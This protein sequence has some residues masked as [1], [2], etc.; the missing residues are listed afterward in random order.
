MEY[1]PARQPGHSASC[2]L[3]LLHRPVPHATQGVVAELSASVHP[4][5][6]P[7]HALA[8]AALNV[9]APQVMHSSLLS[10]PAL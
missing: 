3:S 7:L 5:G 4:F 10:E 6:H 2:E 1:R 8:P 9:P